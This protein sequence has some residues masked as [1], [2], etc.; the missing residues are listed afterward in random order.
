MYGTILKPWTFTFQKLDVWP[1]LIH[2]LHINSY[3]SQGKKCGCKK[4]GCKEKKVFFLNV[5][6]YFNLLIFRE[7]TIGKRMVPCQKKYTEKRYLGNAFSLILFGANVGGR[8]NLRICLHNM[9]IYSVCLHKYKTFTQVY[10]QHVRKMLHCLPFFF[11]VLCCFLL[12]VCASRH[13]LSE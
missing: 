7:R 4:R 2:F 13:P 5:P 10:V 11:S 1:P 9:Y 8:Y 3:H 6:F 12:C